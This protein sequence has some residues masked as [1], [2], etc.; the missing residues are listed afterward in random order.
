MR[1]NSSNPRR[2][3]RVN[4]AALNR[5]PLIPRTFF[6]TPWSM[7][8]A[9]KGS[10]GFAEWSQAMA[11]MRGNPQFLYSFQREYMRTK[12]GIY[13][14]GSEAMSDEDTE[15]K[16]YSDL[17]WVNDKTKFNVLRTKVAP[18]ARMYGNYLSV[19]PSMLAFVRYRASRISQGTRKSLVGV[20]PD[21]LPIE[22]DGGGVQVRQAF[23]DILILN[24]VLIANKVGNPEFF[25]E[26]DMLLRFLGH[27]GYD[28]RGWI[29]DPD[30]THLGRWLVVLSNSGLKKSPNIGTTVAREITGSIRHVG[31]ALKMMRVEFIRKWMSKTDR[32]TGASGRT[33]VRKAAI[34]YAQDDADSLSRSASLS[35]MRSGR[36][37]AAIQADLSRTQRKKGRRDGYSADTIRNTIKRRDKRRT[38]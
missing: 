37:M 10:E 17:D 35:G 14:K 16:L 21:E 33:K 25:V 22:N 29:S 38:M 19:S 30:S 4:E 8:S 2:K 26:A 36:S 18:L 24:Q 12:S 3:M 1:H 7:R 28:E 34:F 23:T 13:L 15:K 6:M 31:K 11:K 20:N 9:P 32:E 5:I 27:A